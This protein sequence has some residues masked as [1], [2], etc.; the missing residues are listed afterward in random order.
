VRVLQKH[1]SELL[2]ALRKQARLVDVLRRQT[3]MIEAA[4]TLSFTEREFEDV[5]DMA[6]AA[7]SW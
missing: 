3:M 5:M 1:R 6:A 2:A 7:G 4:N